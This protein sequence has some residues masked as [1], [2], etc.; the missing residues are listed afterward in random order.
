MDVLFPGIGEIIGGSQR[1]ER[2][3]RIRSA[4]PPTE[5]SG[6]RFVVVSGTCANSALLHTAGFGLG[7]SNDLMLYSLQ[8]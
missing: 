2:Y 4:C 7:L 1:E 8:G 3:D 5:P 6:K